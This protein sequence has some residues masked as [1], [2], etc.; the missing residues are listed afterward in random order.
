MSSAFLPLLSPSCSHLCIIKL[1]AEDPVL[2]GTLVPHDKKP[3]TLYRAGQA[4]KPRDQ[5]SGRDCFTAGWGQWKSFCVTEHL[6]YHKVLWSGTWSGFRVFQRLNEDWLLKG[7]PKPSGQDVCAGLT[8]EAQAILAWSFT[9]SSEINTETSLVLLTARQSRQSK[10]F[11]KL[12][13]IQF[14]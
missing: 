4:I 9:W 2:G 5:R 13:S 14:L 7:G 1:D 8:W 10:M 12:E 6:D 3:V 11:Y